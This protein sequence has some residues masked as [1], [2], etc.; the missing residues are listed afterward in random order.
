[1]KLQF[2]IVVDKTK[3]LTEIV[4]PEEPKAGHFFGVSVTDVMSQKTEATLSVISK[5]TGTPMHVLEKMHFRDL[6]V[7]LAELMAFLG[8]SNQTPSGEPESS[9]ESSTNS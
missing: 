4:F 8:F 2:P 3:T 1:M 9:E 7:L 5:A 6:L